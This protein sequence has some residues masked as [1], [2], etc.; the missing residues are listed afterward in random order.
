M[1]ENIDAENHSKPVTVVLGAGTCGLAAGWELCRNGFPA[2]ILEKKSEIGGLTGRRIIN[3]N[4]Y[5]YGTHVF[6]TDNQKLKKDL[7]ALMGS[8]MFEFDRGS[9]LYIKFFNKYFR[10]PL[11]GADFIRG[12]PFHLLI[13]C[14]FDFIIYSF[15]DLFKKDKYA[16]GEEVL[17]Y[18]F[19]NKLYTIFFR[20]YSAK[21]W[22]KPLRDLDAE[23]VKERIPRSDVLKVVKDLTERLGFEKKIKNHALTEKVIGKLHYTK[24]GI[25]GI[26]DQLNKYIVSH[27]GEVCC[28]SEITQITPQDESVRIRYKTGE[29]EHEIEANSLI[30]SI[31]LPILIGYLP[32]VPAHVKEAAGRL[33]YR[34]LVVLGLLVNKRPVTDA[35][36]FYF[37]NKVFN[38]MAEPTN[39]GL[40]TVSDKHSILLLELTCEYGDKVWQFS[41]DLVESM[42]E[43]LTKEDFIDRKDILEAHKLKINH[44]YPVYH[45]GYKDDIKVVLDYISR[46]NNIQ[47]V[48]RQGQFSYVNIHKTM[49]MGMEA[50]KTIIKQWELI[51]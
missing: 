24:D 46:Y 43:D 3:D 21:Q 36:C 12:L 47:S 45:I 37:Q 26:P 2:T 14:V 9:R 23:F 50:S 51:R 7:C 20:D 25:Y 22:G 17:K 5:E 16:N 49:Q 8:Y 48:G 29:G 34:A 10:Y 1:Q 41:D 27:G 6:H 18:K 33:K 13:H 31:P 42:I 28:G 19:G 11:N 38:R 40:K 35:I 15:L 30:S 39:H 4:S 44:A 32:S